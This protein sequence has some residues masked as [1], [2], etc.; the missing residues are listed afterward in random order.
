MK[1][2]SGIIIDFWAISTLIITLFLSTL[3]NIEAHR[4]AS[5][6]KVQA[7]CSGDYLPK[8]NKLCSKYFKEKSN[9]KQN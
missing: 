9:G 2:R 6:C 3:S 8:Y 1:K 4:Q 7:I 5:W